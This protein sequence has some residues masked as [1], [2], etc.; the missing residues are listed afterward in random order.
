MD[1]SNTSTINAHHYQAG[2]VLYGAAGYNYSGR[3]YT[4][5]SQYR[6]D[7][8][9]TPLAPGT[10]SNG[11]CVSCHM[12]GPD[13]TS[14]HLFKAISTTTATALVNGLTKTTITITNI[15]SGVC[16]TCHGPDKTAFLALVSQ[17]KNY[18]ADAQSALQYAMELSGFY[19]RGSSFYRAR[20]LQ[21]I[22]AGTVT[23]STG[24]K[25]VLGFNT[26]WSLAGVEAGDKFRVDSDGVWYD[27]ATVDSATQLTLTSDFTGT[28]YS[29][30]NYSI[31]KNESVSVTNGSAI[32][33]GTGTNWL[34]TVG[35]I[36]PGDKFKID[37]NGTWYTIATVDTDTQLTLTA[38]Y[39]G[40]T[41]SA[42]FFTLRNT[43]TA[44]VVTTSPTVTVAGA[45]LI[46]LDV[47]LPPTASSGDYFRIDSDGTWYRI[48][49]RTATTL[50]LASAY[51][52]TTVT[53]PYTIIRNVA[54]R[55]WLT[56]GD[57]D[58]S[59][60]TTGKN[61]LGAAYNQ[62]M[63]GSAYDYAAYV[64]NRHYAKKLLYDAIDW[65]D[66]N[67]MNYSAGTTLNASCAV[68]TP[69]AWCAGAMS[70]LLPVG[71]VGN[72]VSTERP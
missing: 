63:F 4:N 71:V 11:G 13:G 26:N 61:N 29:L 6:H 2:A 16:S 42:A 38:N 65:M 25:G 53:G 46:T 9:G 36:A 43:S 39:A 62:I 59:G 57:V 5:P 28:N 34:S 56:R 15:P 20:D 21:V 23:V 31:R 35:L 54:N 72:G 55:N 64:H 27:I 8:I 60:N 45:N 50:T 3:D 67:V 22:S 44:A 14:N 41:T 52:G 68:T 1:F 47:G 37:S 24:N 18:F 10:G 49:N 58:I 51:V 69:P 19:K 33:T 48:T 17:E 66:D 32:V 30:T 70:Y 40:Q 7:Q 12:I